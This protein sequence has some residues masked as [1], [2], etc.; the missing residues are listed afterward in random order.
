MCGHVWRNPHSVLSRLK[1]TKTTVPGEYFLWLV[2]I[3]PYWVWFISWVIGV[4]VDRWT[5][6]NAI[7]LGDNE[8]N[9]F[10]INTSL[11]RR[12]RI[13]NLHKLIEAPL[14]WLHLGFFFTYYKEKNNVGKIWVNAF[15]I[16]P[17]EFLL[18]KLIHPVALTMQRSSG[19]VLTIACHLERFDHICGVEFST[20]PKVVT[21]F[22]V[23]TFD[24]L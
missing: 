16:F 1:E 14:V 20:W 22:V 13:Y 4:Y 17:S 12:K 3:H 10:P 24:V 5:W 15:H 6:Q 8:H 21:K 11:L 23:F 7:R 2:A 19:C 18:K 9:D